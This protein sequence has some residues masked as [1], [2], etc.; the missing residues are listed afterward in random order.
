[1][2]IVK[3]EFRNNADVP[4][5]PSH[6]PSRIVAA[7]VDDWLAGLRSANTR[8]AYASDFRR[9]ADWCAAHDVDPVQI[10]ERELRRFRAAIERSGV[11]SSTT[12]RRLSAVASF[13]AF[14][15][16]R[17]AAASFAEVDRPTVNPA[18]TVTA[19]D[20][21]DADALLRAADDIDARVGVLV[22]LLMLDGLKVG[23]AAAADAADVS[24]RPP[25]L[26]LAVGERALRLHPDTS[27]LLQGYLGRR[28]VGPLL[29]SEGRARPS[30]R[31]SRYGVDYLIKEVANAAGLSGS[32]SG[33]TLRRRY[34][35]AAH[36]NGVALDNI[37]QAAGHADV[38]T[39]RRYLGP[40]P[41]DETRR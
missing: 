34:V 25:T 7:L 2:L 40:D 17:G 32:I 41:T 38:R 12:A 37:R 33:N 28:R 10:D 6:V 24:G 8:A 19:L 14:A 1:M 30:D 36:A 35:V 4:R 29:L 20:D 39:T 31:L 27:F 15:T 16:A 26:V 13:G 9:F 21:A 11:S 22:R 3:S 18:S 23:E 5:R